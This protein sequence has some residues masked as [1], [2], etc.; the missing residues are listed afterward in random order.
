MRK[1][2][3][4]LCA[5]LAC[6][7]AGCGLHNNEPSVEE[8]DYNFIFICPILDNVYWQECAC[9]IAAAD[10]ELGTATRII[11][12]QSTEDFTVE[13]LG[14]M[15]DAIAA[16]PDGIMGYAGVEGMFP[17]IDRAVAQ[18]IPF[19]AV[20]S[21]APE[22]AR[23]AYVG[24][25]LYALG[26][27]AGETMVQLTGGSASIG[28]LCS[29]YSVQGEATAF[30]S[31]QDAISDFHME[32]VATAEGGVTVDTAE[33][34]AL[35][36][37]AEHPEITAVF[38]TAN[39]NITGVARAKETLGRD[40]LILVGVDDTE[41]NLEFVRKGVIDA[42]LAQSPYQMGYRSVYLMKECVDQGGSLPKEN[43]DTGSVLITQENVNQYKKTSGGMA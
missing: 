36:M 24:T 29:S 23:A 6:L 21:D 18:D 19:L 37:L 9:G 30:D 14:H 1:T 25:D 5:V 20:D 33:E 15:E 40:D 39:Y 13:I 31:F 3:W 2:I 7:M 27:Q 10:Q 28:Y 42:L 32:I 16:N 41:E 38:C 35:A 12:P 34:A 22:T 4:L 17:L 8:Q 26:Y 11:G 43:Y